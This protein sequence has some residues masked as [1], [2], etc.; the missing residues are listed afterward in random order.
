MIPMNV[1]VTGA[2]GFI[3]F[4]VSKRLLEDG[5]R[6]VGFDNVNDYYDIKLMDFVTE[7]E[8][9]LGIPAQL[10]LMPMQPGDIPKS[11]AD[12][13]NLIEEFD[14]A[15][16]HSIQHGIKN[17]IDWYLDYYKTVLNSPVGKK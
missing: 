1:L 4:H 17:F 5:Y 12:V 13:E 2:A 14:Y 10:N 3:G 6:V 16:Q 7:I 15:P 11:H 9:N 8:K